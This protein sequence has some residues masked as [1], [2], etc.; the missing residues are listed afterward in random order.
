MTGNV[1]TRY[2]SKKSEPVVLAAINKLNVQCG[3]YIIL[4]LFNIFCN[5]IFLDETIIELGYGRGDGLKR[6][7]DIIINGKGTIYGL[8]FSEYMRDVVEHRFAIELVD[9]YKKLILE[10]VNKNQSIK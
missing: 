1:L 4:I 10:N 7:Y 3:N 8:E 2:W 6:V 5:L 9:T